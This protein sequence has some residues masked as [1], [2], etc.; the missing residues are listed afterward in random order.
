MSAPYYRM[1]PREWD[2]GTMGLTL[3]Q[4]G[5]LVRICNAINSRGAPIPDDEKTNREMAHRCRVSFRKWLTLK[6]ALLD[7]GHIKIESD[8]INIFQKLP[9][10]NDSGNR[11]SLGADV[12]ASVFSE[13]KCAYCGA[14]DGIMEI[15]HIYPVSRGGGNERENLTLACRSCNRQKADRTPQEWLR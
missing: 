2:D 6:A 5:A 10:I 13:G 14:T 9:A 4:E 12:I 3:E 11:K 15:D 7:A 1:F 8:A